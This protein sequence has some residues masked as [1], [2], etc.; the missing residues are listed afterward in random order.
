[1]TEVHVVC[2]FK[3]EK[4]ERKIKGKKSK[5][6]PSNLSELHLYHGFIFNRPLILAWFVRNVQ[7]FRLILFLQ[8][9][10]E[11]SGPQK[12]G[13]QEGVQGEEREQR[14]EQ[15][16]PEGQVGRLWRGEEWK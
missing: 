12:D 7:S 14:G 6:H 10:S 9:F 15:G 4:K 3:K 16:E 11:P 13:S 5:Y 1:M 2:G 8:P